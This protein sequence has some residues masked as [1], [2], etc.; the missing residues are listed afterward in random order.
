MKDKIFRKLPVV[1]QTE[2]Q[3]EFF[4]ATVD[5][6]FST[7][8]SQRAQGFIGRRS[9]GVFNPTGDTYLSEPTK[10]RA[11]YQLEPIAYSRVDGEDTNQFF[12]EDLLNHL[13]FNRGN[14]S[15]H[16]RLF[17]DK[18]YSFAPPI[19]LDK[20]VNYQS[21]VWLPEGIPT[22][23]I[24]GLDDGDIE[25]DI[26]GQEFFNTG[27]I[28][29]AAP[30]N[31]EFTSGLR[32]RFLGSTSY[33]AEYYVE[34]VGRSIRLV[35]MLPSGFGDFTGGPLP[36]DATPIGLGSFWD[37]FT[38]DAGLAERASNEDYLTIERGACDG[39]P[40]SRSNRWFHQSTLAAVE[41]VGQIV[42]A[43]VRV[44]GQDYV[45]GDIF[46][47]AGDGTGAELEVTAVDALGSIV[48]VQIIAVGSGYTQADIVDDDPLT[49]ASNSALG[50]GAEI[51]IFL[52]SNINRSRRARRPI[53]EFQR[54]LELFNSGRR[55]IGTVDL[56]IENQ[57][58]FALTGQTSATI[59]GVELEEDMLVIFLTSDTDSVWQV[60]DNGGTID[61][62]QYN[63]YIQAPAASTVCE[64]DTV[65]VV[66][67]SDNSASMFYQLNGEWIRSQEKLDQNQAPLF[68]A[69]NVDG[70]PLDDEAF[71][72][73]TDFSGTPIFTYKVGTIDE[74]GT[75][76]LIN[77]PV[78]GFPV[79]RTGLGQTSDL[80]FE[81]SLEANRYTFQYTGL[82]REEVNGLYFYGRFTDACTISSSSPCV[83]RSPELESTWVPSNEPA[84]QRVVDRFLISEDGQNTFALSLRPADEIDPII[85]VSLDGRI[86]NTSEVSY[87]DTTNSVVLSTSGLNEGLL[88][89]V[90]TYSHSRLQNSQPGFFEIPNEL[91]NNPNNHEVREQSWNEF[92]KHFI[93]IIQNQTPYEGAAFGSTNNYRDSA[94]DGSVG[95]FILQ[96]QSPLLK[97]MLASS[98]TDLDV[99]KAM[100]F[101][102]T[103][104]TRYKNKIVKYAQQLYNEGFT[105]FNVGD[106]LPISQWMDEVIRRI[107]KSREYKNAFRDTYMIAWSSIYEE[108]SILGTELVGDAYV[109]D[110]IADPNMVLDLDDKRNT[111]YVYVD[112]QLQVLGTDYVVTDQNP[113]SIQFLY[114]P[115]PA[116]TITIRL[117]ENSTPAH[118]PATPSKQGIYPVSVP[119]FEQDDTYPTPTGVIVG[120]DGSRTPMFGSIADPDIVDQLLLE[121]EVRIYNAIVP[122]FRNDYE[123][124][125]MLEDIK[126]GYFRETRWSRRQYNDLI[127]ASFFK[128]A[129]Y[130]RADFKVNEFSDIADEWT[131]N[132]TGLTMPDGFVLRGS[133]RNL[134]EQFYDT[135]TPHLTPWEMLGFSEKPSWWESTPNIGDGFTGYGPGP[136]PDVHPMWVDLEAGL[137]RRG[138]RAGV[139]ERFARPGLIADH[140]PVDAVGD[141]LPTPADCIGYLGPMP[142]EALVT[143]EWTFGDLSPVEH[144]W[145][146]SEAYPYAVA[147]TLFLARPGEFGE[148]Y[149][150][151]EI[152]VR[153]AA[154]PRQ[155]ITTSGYRVGNAEQ[156]VHGETRNGQQVVRTGWQVF[157]SSRLRSL[158]K[159]VRD[160]FGRKVRSLDV[161]LGHK[162]ASFTNEET[163]R[164]F[165]EG[166][167]VASTTT[168]L[169]IPTENVTVDLH[170]SPPVRE[171]FYGGVLIRANA[172]ATYSVYGYD[173]LSE[174]F[175]Y[176][177]RRTSPNDQNINVGGTSENFLQWETGRR[178]ERGTIIRVNGVFYRALESHDATRFEADKWQRLSKL[179]IVGGINVTY[180]P[181]GEPFFRSLEYGATLF[182]PQEVFDFLIGY[183]EWLE[184]EGFVFENLNEDA[185]RLENWLVAAKEFLFWVGTN[186]EADSIIQLSPAAR[187][188]ELN[189]QEG[190]P[191]N[192]DRI[193]NGVY[194]ILDKN[195]VV[196]DPKSTQIRRKDRNLR[197]LPLLE[198][199]G[200][201][202]LRVNTTETESIVSFDNVTQFD[203]TLYSP[204][205]G[206]RVERVFF[207]GLQTLDWTG[208][209]EAGGYIITEDGVKPNFENLVNSIRLYH[210]TEDILDNPQIE[211]VTRH[212]IG[213]EE[214]EYFD[215][216]QLLD[217]NQYL[218][219]QGFLR[220][221]GTTRALQKIQRS[222][223]IAGLDDRLEIFEDWALKLGEYGATCN[224]QRTEFFLRASEII[225]DPQLVE[226]HYPGGVAAGQTATV[227]SYTVVSA[228][229]FWVT[230]PA[231]TVVTHPFD[232]GTGAT[233]TAVLDSSGR[234]IRVDVLNP[235][236]GYTVPPLVYINQTPGDTTL[237]DTSDRVI[238]NIQFPIS[239]NSNICPC[240]IGIDVDDRIRWPVRPSGSSCAIPGELWP[241]EKA[242]S[243]GIP[244]AGYVHMAD[245]DYSIFSVGNLSSLW[246]LPNPPQ[247]GNTIH[248]ARADDTKWNVYQISDGIR[249]VEIVSIAGSAVLPTD[250]PAT[251]NAE[252]ELSI[253]SDGT[254]QPNPNVLIPGTGQVSIDNLPVVLNNG[255][256]GE[257]SVEAD[258]G[259]LTNAT[260][261]TEGEGYGQSYVEMDLPIPLPNNVYAPA[262]LNLTV[263]EPADAKVVALLP[264]NVIVQSGGFGY[265]NSAFSLSSFTAPITGAIN[266]GI[267]NGSIST[268]TITSTLETDISSE[269][270]AAANE[271]AATVRVTTGPAT[272]LAQDETDF[273]LT[274][275]NGGFSSG[276][277][278]QV[279]DTI[280]LSNGTELIV[281]DVDGSGIVTEFEITKAA[282]LV[283]WFADNGGP[284]AGGV[285]FLVSTSSAAGEIFALELGQSNITNGL[286]EVEIL[287][288]GLGYASGTINIDDISSL[289][290]DVEL[291]AANN[292]IE[293]G[294]VTVTGGGYPVGPIDIS[295]SLPAT[296][297]VGT[298][299]PAVVK[300]TSNGVEVTNPGFGYENGT[301]V[302]TDILGTGGQMTFNVFANAIMGFPIINQPLV[303]DISADLPAVSSA[304]GGISQVEITSGGF[305]YRD[306]VA[307]NNVRGLGA[308]IMLYAANGVIT[309]AEIV[310]PGLGYLPNSTFSQTAPM[311]DTTPNLATLNA[312]VS[313]RGTIAGVEVSS[314][315]V[316]YF[317]PATYNLAFNNGTG[318]IIS[319][320]VNNNGEVSTVTVTQ[321]GENYLVPTTGTVTIPGR[322]LSKDYT[323]TINGTPVT[324]GRLSIT[325][326]ADIVSTINA[327]NVPGIEATVLSSDDLHLRSLSD[328]EL[329]VEA[330]D[331]D[332]AQWE[333]ET[334]L[335]WFTTT[336]FEVVTR[337]ATEVFLNSPVG[338]TIPIGSTAVD[339]AALLSSPNVTATAVDNQLFVRSRFNDEF[340][341]IGDPVWERDVVANV[342]YRRPIV[343]GT[344]AFIPAISSTGLV[345]ITVGPQP[346]Q[347]YADGTYTV[348]VAS[349]GGTGA[350]VELEAVGGQI[351]SG[352]VIQSGSGYTPGTYSISSDVPPPQIGTARLR[353]QVNQGSD[354][355]L[356]EYQPGLCIFDNKISK[357][358]LSVEDTFLDNQIVIEGD[359]YEYELVNVVDSDTWLYALSQNGVP[360]DDDRFNT[361]DDP[362]V[363]LP[364]AFFYALRY[365]SVSEVMA[366]ADAL[367]ALQPSAARY[368]LDDN[369]NGLWEVRNLSHGTER[370]ETPLIITRNFK[371]AFIYDSITKDTLSQMP[372][373]DPFKGILPG[374]ADRNITY[375][376]LNDPARYT[377]AS[378]ARLVDSSKTFGRDNVG[379]VWWDLSTMAYLWYEQGSNRYRRD[380]W[381]QLVNGSSIDVYEWVR[382]VNPPAQWAGS[383]TPRNT[384][385]YVARQ[386][387][388]A[389]L[390]ET[391]TFYYFW[392]RNKIEVPSNRSRTL[393][394]SEVA[395]IIQNPSAQNFRWFSPVSPN[396]YMFAGIDGVFTDSDNFF[397]INYTVIGNNDNRHVQ[398]ELGREGDGRY[399]P[400]DYHW[401][402]M[403]DSLVGLTEPVPLAGDTGV[404][405]FPLLNYKNAIPTAADPTIGYL[406]VPD[407]TLSDSEKYG[408]RTRPQQ[409]MFMN[410]REAR[411]VFVE[412]VNKLLSPILLRDENEAWSSPSPL[413]SWVDWWAD[414]YDEDNTVPLIMVNFTGDLNLLTDLLDGDVVMV[415]G[416]PALARPSYYVWNA[417]TELFDLVYKKDTRLALN[418]RIF[419]EQWNVADS[420]E[421]RR[422][423]NN[424]RNFVLTGSRSVNINLIFFSML[425]YVFS[426]QD[427][428][429][430]AFKTTYLTI[431]QLG[432][433]M[434]QNRNFQPSLVDNVLQ[435]LNEA[436]PYHTKIRD[437]ALIREAQTD[438]LEGTAEEL[439]RFTTIKMFYDRIQCTLTLT[440][441]RIAK[442]YPDFDGYATLPS[443]NG[444]VQV[445]L[446]HAGRLARVLAQQSPLIPTILGTDYEDFLPGTVPPTSDELAVVAA[447]NTY[448]GQ[449]LG[450]PFD[451]YFHLNYGPQENQ[452]WSAL[453]PDPAPHPWN[454]G[455]WSGEPPDSITTHDGV[456]NASAPS[457]NFPP[458]QTFVGDGGQSIFGLSPALPEDHFLFVVINNVELV[459]NVDYFFINGAVSF[460]APPPVDANIEIYSII[461]AGGLN[462]PMVS[463]GI[464]D[465][466]IPL[467]PRETLIINV[468]TDEP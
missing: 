421:L 130:N 233:G 463:A 375:K 314:P 325:G 280:T 339:I 292:E 274:G 234:L 187:G 416:D 22:L 254:L 317:S 362:D 140:L 16:D 356:V 333:A 45:V 28:T 120:H 332:E 256:A 250:I 82:P 131:W 149:W 453:E 464:L 392:V 79:V 273:D 203:D 129:N 401:N 81:H 311:P 228:T 328:R 412:T 18:Y 207:N 424:L 396:A 406:L 98:S 309:S 64:Y 3:R 116:D 336:P 436:K 318:A 132:Y 316:G 141:L 1:F 267:V 294:V 121:F 111:M 178:Y 171:Y 221:K 154:D 166:V 408:I 257:I 404:E 190:Y 74:I 358:V 216:L 428:L 268:A 297:P 75:A 394:V 65:Y 444:D 170:T 305:G 461:D 59:D 70:L 31:F 142:T 58:R 122:R 411:K 205:L 198:G 134:F 183:G 306:T 431:R 442:S 204:L 315:G 212:L 417:R 359:L 237:T 147:E 279:G 285:I 449:A 78:L 92:S 164:T 380:N 222:S 269:F 27:Q 253:G 199:Q 445:R 5:Q 426:E 124:P 284:V 423:V 299:V 271:I 391:R 94:K 175:R 158:G 399:T 407:P 382:S 113:I 151:P 165:V 397:Q 55:Y 321:P 69:Y 452:P 420:V 144:V 230:P 150:D 289:G 95:T 115:S 177:P 68:R 189:V 366:N 80:I 41:A 201:F 235:G 435:Y 373:Y 386:E 101:S 300:V 440:E 185:G 13:S 180:K 441:M 46:T 54:D 202:A 281:N 102:A 455:G 462:N 261:L 232:S 43:S 293:S 182:N 371:N 350:I 313:S 335:A 160:E 52:T 403:L 108:K 354:I 367:N 265:T 126:P 251:E 193:V 263:N 456:V 217:D 159:E 157:V 231:V 128:W 340:I 181:E 341:L 103:E 468:D 327:A 72:P 258:G 287:G 39:N 432:T 349:G 186:W 192:V 322:V 104:Y 390:E 266:F 4:N 245:V 291:T 244:N 383:G 330:P 17:S 243:Y 2:T 459:R 433:P 90:R 409:S 418:G 387:F 30:S 219:Y 169:L 118:V 450:C 337:E 218:F 320:N 419:E 372:V 310:N 220:E 117:Y 351:V 213:F 206:Q 395:R 347:R 87:D 388:D 96:N 86:L 161:K 398:W 19:D 393:S 184:R 20:F 427:D 152:L 15:N 50:T 275:T 377:N 32:V 173:I 125:L 264:G 105:P 278:F 379:E 307:L 334:G 162:M 97:A 467:D 88:V 389:A 361:D 239:D 343:Q 7:T 226:L 26:I 195:G 29:G 302:L 451:G 40:W 457:F 123:Q 465:E 197:C 430:W 107:I 127:K 429:D 49:P 246:D 23:I 153:A 384:T 304:G 447:I 252:I 283:Q 48:Q 381:G 345:S 298:A 352:T 410:L 241:E 290:G 326:L 323:F 346:H 214:R 331:G 73:N 338:T 211:N 11:A 308:N 405:P 146:T 83:A 14:I 12:Y 35:P 208:K 85:E 276:M 47:V 353:R 172:D 402:R 368:W 148:K 62:V 272:I 301:L 38:W 155:L 42:G 99:L 369:D 71:F 167:S 438:L 248:V 370:V 312:I 454:T 145:F 109:V 329:V 434:Q 296:S 437:Y 136:W 446:G 6:L 168:S 458:L 286:H 91:E 9:G 466:M 174:T 112:G 255:V 36:W 34:G 194:S 21:Y 460:V 66:R 448:V 200:V 364:A 270:P 93:S 25:S 357:D 282:S 119:R 319:Y 179:P 133:W 61:F 191:S 378:D 422:I 225:V 344:F 106:T 360:I 413:W 196:I 135:Q 342:F 348:E 363:N 260:L 288:R 249:E 67:G 100:R 143:A 439:D 414:G 89:E 139:D 53:I 137:I 37:T 303:F 110:P 376:T 10:N 44:P 365:R 156:Y 210:S 242:T 223:A 259:E 238:A 138:N 355:P 385:D 236:T 188:V 443:A 60:V 24:E 227:V 224:N 240:S 76:A 374:P 57:T 215:N 56:V 114:S 77:D 277:N 63:M 415:K 262:T 176:I 400:N 247:I 209:L 51:S 163:L 8:N 84:M 33:D 324:F 229:N 425:N 295:A